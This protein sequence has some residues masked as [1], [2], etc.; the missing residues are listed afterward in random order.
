MSSFN[1]LYDNL[2]FYLR[3]V[4]N[5]TTDTT[6][7]STLGSTALVIPLPNQ[8]NSVDYSLKTEHNLTFNIRGDRI[9]RRSIHDF[10]PTTITITGDIRSKPTL[11]PRE[12]SVRIAPGVVSGLF[13]NHF[14][15]DLMLS[16]SEEIAD[17]FAKALNE[18]R[19]PRRGYG[20]T[21][22]AKKISDRLQFIDLQR[23]VVY[24]SCEIDS[25]VITRDTSANKFGY[26]FV[27]KLIS[28]G[29]PSTIPG[30]NDSYLSFATNALRYLNSK[31]ATLNSLIDNFGDGVTGPVADLTS[32]LNTLSSQVA[33]LSNAPRDTVLKAKHT[34]RA[35]TGAFFNALSQVILAI[36]R[37]VLGTIAVLKDGQEWYDVTKLDQFISATDYIIDTTGEAPSNTLLTI[38][39]AALLL[40]QQADEVQ[41][42]AAVLRGFTG[43]ESA[44]LLSSSNG[45][46]LG[47]DEAIQRLAGFTYPVNTVQQGAV[48]E[49]RHT[50]KYMVR[51]GESIF[52]IAARFYG[53]IN[54][55]TDIAALN[56]MPTPYIFADNTPVEPGSFIELPAELQL[57]SNSNLAED[58]LL[59]D[60]L[61][62]DGD[63]YFTDKDLSIVS[64][65]Q[66][67]VQ[68]LRNRLSTRQGEL[69]FIP[70]YGLSGITGNLAAGFTADMIGIEVTEQLL[71]DERIGLVTNVIT[72]LAGDHIDVQ[73]ALTLA[74]NETLE[75]S[76]PII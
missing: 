23:G 17:A 59:T 24:D 49:G 2:K 36:P 47:N 12:G 30:V 74:N 31:I 28:Y 41:F 10:T 29:N 75:V 62:V 72:E 26:G 39:S 71:S 27:L 53:D 51:M 42:Q 19:R 4:Q 68:A 18:Y 48:G 52:D 1:S 14:E 6:V 8:P 54:S 50:F 15:L 11:Y 32:Q 44:P 69:A 64:G 58:P 13:T 67:M 21:I 3:V 70:A 60:L 63:L 5:S 55:W 34:S 7:N 22:T 73:V 20:D 76:V 38:D 66:N 65:M 37:A 35:V 16:T 61:L 57:I 40:G 46:F 9:V 56:R 43:T 25:F 45:G 33:I